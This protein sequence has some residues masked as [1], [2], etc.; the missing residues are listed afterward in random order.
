M[1]LMLLVPVPASSNE[2]S[3]TSGRYMHDSSMSS[4]LAVALIWACSRC[5]GPPNIIIARASLRMNSCRHTI[6]ATCRVICTRRNEKREAPVGID[7]VQKLTHISAFLR[8]R[9]FS[10]FSSKLLA[11]SSAPSSVAGVL[12]TVLGV[13]PANLGRSLSTPLQRCLPV[14]GVTGDCEP[15]LEEWGDS[16]SSLAGVGGP[17]ISGERSDCESKWMLRERVRGLRSAAEPAFGSLLSSRE[18]LRET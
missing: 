17:V 3:I 6:S 9:R 1:N 8:F 11:P 14:S 15:P 16:V 10:R 7:R 18:Y 4:T 13:R 5:V 12:G 2:M